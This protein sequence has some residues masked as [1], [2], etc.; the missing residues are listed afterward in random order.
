M[1]SVPLSS[2]GS[3]LSGANMCRAD[4]DQVH[5]QLALPLPLK[6]FTF[7][8]RTEAS[9]TISIIQGGVF[10]KGPYQELL[11]RQITI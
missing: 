7:L 4:N 11:T 9:G 2:L 6:D 5:T 3:A 8:P 1:G 10:A